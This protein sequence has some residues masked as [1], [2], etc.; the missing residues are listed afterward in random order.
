MQKSTKNSFENSFPYGLQRPNKERI[1]KSVE[2]Q[3]LLEAGRRVVQ[4]YR[5]SCCDQRACPAPQ[6]RPLALLSCD[7]H[8]E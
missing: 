3:A 1:N 7:C 4:A 2:Q 6:Q 5:R 8:M